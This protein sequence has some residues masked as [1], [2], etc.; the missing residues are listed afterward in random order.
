MHFERTFKEMDAVADIPKEESPHGRNKEA[1]TKSEVIATAV[2]IIATV[3]G[4]Y[5]RAKGVDVAVRSDDVR[6][7]RKQ[8]EDKENEELAA[9]MTE[10]MKA[11]ELVF[12]NKHAKA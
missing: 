9:M 5:M 4:G 7:L 10:A 3:I 2:I 1:I 11:C 12:K 8:A 6:G